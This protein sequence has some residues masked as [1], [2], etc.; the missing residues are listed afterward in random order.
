MKPLYLD[1]RTKLCLI[2]LC[3][4]NAMLTPN[5]YFQLALVMLIGLL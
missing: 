2:L 5:L 4:L 3:V 1:P